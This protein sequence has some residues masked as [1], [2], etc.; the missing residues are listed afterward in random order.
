MRLCSWLT[1]NNDPSNLQVHAL[2]IPGTD[3]Q[4]TLEHRTFS[5]PTKHTPTPTPGG[6]SGHLV[7]PPTKAPDV[8]PLSTTPQLRLHRFVGA[9]F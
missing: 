2:S 6:A 8:L 7:G 3:M 4:I 9:A 1:L 5:S